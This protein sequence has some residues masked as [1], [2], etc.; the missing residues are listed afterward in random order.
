M[1]RIGAPPEAH[2]VVEPF[3]GGE[4][5][6]GPELTGPA[7]TRRYKDGA[8]VLVL[9]AGGVLPPGSRLLFVVRRDGRLDPVTDA[10]EPLPQP[11][12]RL[13]LLAPGGRGTTQDQQ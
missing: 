13:V 9:P 7:F 10:G 4:V 8:A 3:I 5:L 6:F 11:G 1:H 12:D 2:G